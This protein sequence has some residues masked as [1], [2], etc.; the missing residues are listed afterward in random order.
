M[1]STV[2]FFRGG[3]IGQ[4]IIQ[5]QAKLSSR[6]G[7]HPLSLQSRSHLQLRAAVQQKHKGGDRLVQRM[8]T[9]YNPEKEMEERAKSIDMKIKDGQTLQKQQTR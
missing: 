3:G 6:M 9:V 7:F 8:A 2:V 1:W 4:G 5:G